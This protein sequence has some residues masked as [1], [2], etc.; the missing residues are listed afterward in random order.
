MAVVQISK[1]QHRRGRVNSGGSGLPQLASGELGWAIDEQKLYIGNGSVSEGAPY[2]GNTEVLTEHTNILDLV[3]QYQYKRDDSTIQTGSSAAIP[4]QRSLQDRLDDAISVR[5][6]G[7]EGDGVADD[8][9]ALQRA[10]D[11][12]YINVATVGSAKSRIILML[13]AGVY[14]ITAP[15]RIPPYAV[16]HG[17][18]KDKTFIQQT[19]NYPV[20][21]TVNSSST[22]GNYKDLTDLDALNQPQYL[23]V[24]GITFENTVAGYPV[25]DLIATKNSIFKEV[26]FKG[27]WDYVTGTSITITTIA[28]AKTFAVA[29]DH[30]LAVGDEIFPRVTANGL[31]ANQ[32]YYVK[33]VPT[34]TTFTL[35]S[36]VDGTELTSF[37]NGTSLSIL[38]E[39][40]SNNEVGLRLTALSA[41]VTCSNNYFNNCDFVN[42]SYA[43]DSTYDI[44]SNTF[45]E[46]KFSQCSRGIRFGHNVNGITA[47]RLYGPKNNSVIQSTFYQIKEVGFDVVTGTGNSSQSN[48]YIKVGTDGGTE[49]TAIYS[50]I[51]FVSSGNV[52]TGDLFDRSIELTTNPE[53]INDVR[54]VGEVTGQIKSE[55]KFN[56]SIELLSLQTGSPLLRL[57]ADD[58][59]SHVVH[60]FY[61]SQAQSVTRQGSIHINSDM[62][63]DQVHITDDCSVIGNSLN[64][65]KL[66]FSAT[67]EDAD[68]DSQKDTI[69]LRY[70]NTATSENGYIN[71]WYESL[72]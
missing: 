69:Y 34:T 36:T 14:K 25:V 61:K 24:E 65:E 49:E 6:F 33:S 30:S 68:G 58:S 53:Y 8:T 54:Y 41:V 18:G 5:S 19:G 4:I 40:L 46:C 2:V 72:S 63:N 57:P 47:G 50:V 64:F 67:L 71:Y 31:V 1:I 28:D 13:E 43:V 70:T 7:A 38:A 48:K 42:V 37:T 17:A 39:K 60:Y 23:D 62:T 59:V 51:N 35:T 22:P 29:T 26:K 3:G 21:Y 10:I 11:Q 55:H 66:T 15:L 9:A 12:L 45:F 20:A 27:V 16:L 44:D 52:S 32:K 56:N